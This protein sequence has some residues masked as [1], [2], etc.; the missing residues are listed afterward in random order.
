[1]FEEKSTETVKELK[2]FKEREFVEKDA[3]LSIKETA[4]NLFKRL[5]DRKINS[6]QELEQFLLDRSE[7]E[8]ALMEKR[9]IL[10]IDMTCHT[11]DKNKASAYQ[12][13]MQNVMPVVEL[14]SNSLDKKFIEVEKEFFLEDDRYFVLKR[15]K[16]NNI[17]LFNE[18]NIDLHKE[19]SNLQQEYQSING[20]MTVNFR[21][22]ERTLQQMGLFL[23][24]NDRE[25]R[26]EAWLKTAERRIQDKEKIEDIFEQLINIRNQEAKNAG[27][28]N[29]RDFAFK[30]LERFDYSVEDC[31]K[32]HEAAEKIIIPLL[33][34]IYQ[35]RK[36][37][38]GVD[39]LRPWDLQV[40]IEGKE[41]LRPFSNVSELKQGTLN[42]FQKVD[43]EL[44]SRFKTLID[45]DLLDLESR[46]GKAPGGYQTVLPESRYP[47]IFMNA[48]GVDR[49][50]STLLHEGG[51]AF[52]TFA[53]RKEPLL[54][55]RHGPIEF[56][57]V[58]SM[59]ME[60]IGEEY[61]D[62]FYK[63][64]ELKRSIREHLEL[65]VFIMAWVAAIDAFQHWIYEN[66]EHSREERKQAW[67]DIYNRFGGNLVDWEGLEDLKAH[68]WHKQ[69]HVF[70]HAFYYIEYAIAQLGALGIWNNCQKDKEK[71]LEDYKKAL[72][73]GGSKP[74]PELFQAAGLKFDITEETMRPLFDK[75]QERLSE[76][77]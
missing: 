69:L 50:V 55:Y 67:L 41:P 9:S 66:P 60:L 11:D 23:L 27:F 73:L 48:V 42:I 5:N 6:R 47:F 77:Q 45:N 30:N 34:K 25:L 10:Y 54:D 61:L 56:C 70:I 31:K 46:K 76:V 33:E 53:C 64:D 44:G 49:D 2:P 36:E 62:E 16:K 20:A 29:Y 65:I 12:D 21:G 24:Q 1:M 58:A 39:K 8:S 17:E 72:S 3:D 15:T 38:L 74:L 28:K 52:H 75:L 14:Y 43:P 35:N 19:E 26:E 13:F 51:H 18:K 57:E 40:D 59:S 71:A 37:K 7:L 68:I 32:Y 22:K 4:E 63:P